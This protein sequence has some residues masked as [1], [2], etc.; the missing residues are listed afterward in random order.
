M[1]LFRNT[2][3]LDLGKLTLSFVQIKVAGEALAVRTY[4]YNDDK[5]KKTLLMTHGMALSSA[6]YA[7]LWP[8]LS[9]KY[10]IVAFDHLGHGLNTRT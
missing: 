6:F 3:G 7:R 5:S 4:V 8:K 10:R 9:K 2:D 1:E